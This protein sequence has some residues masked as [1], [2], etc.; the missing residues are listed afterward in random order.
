M[1]KI[2]LFIILAFLYTFLGCK[3]TPKPAGTQAELGID[4][5]SLLQYGYPAYSDTVLDRTYF[6]IA[7]NRNYKIPEWVGYHLTKESLTGTTPR[8]NDFRPDSE[9][10]AHKQASL[11][12]YQKSGYDRGHMAPAGD[13]K[14]NRKAMSTTFLL[15]NIVPQ[16]SE[17]NRNKWEEL[18]ENERALLS[19]YNE[20]WIITGCTFL[21]STMK[22]IT[23][24]NYIGN[25]VYIPTHLYKAILA[26]RPDGTFDT[27][28]F[29]MPNQKIRLLKPVFDY[30]IT[31]D[32]LEILTGLDFF[33][34]LNDEIENSIESTKPI[35]WPAKP[36][37]NN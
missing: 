14:Q 6:I 37:N 16:T 15:T 17:I 8:T 20:L 30:C 22:Q 11:S 36:N 4:T 10:P 21:D 5:T 18:E 32:S 7:Y 1:K 35:Y 3:N 2:A 9:L 12:D 28:A 23:P 13:F 19:F 34:K 26:K 31:I 24:K 25:C 33:N 27:Y 29:I